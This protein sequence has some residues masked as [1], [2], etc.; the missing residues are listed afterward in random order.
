MRKLPLLFVALFVFVN[1]PQLRAQQQT[2]E[3]AQYIR[4]N[5]DKREVRIPMRDGINLFTSIYTPK[6][7]S[8]K[9][10][11]LR[12]RTPYTVAPC[13]EDRY[14]TSLGPNR[15]FAREGYIFVDQ[16][17]RGRWMRKVR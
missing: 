1:V 5:Y 13:G 16:D 11:I 6:D 15:L 3:L 12:N 8:Q 4:E 14:K 10:P 9:Y 17:V 7:K 2:D